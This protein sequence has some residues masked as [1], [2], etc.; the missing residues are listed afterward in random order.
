LRYAAEGKASDVH[1]EPMAD[2]IRVRFRVDGTLNTSLVLP[3]EVHQAV[4]ARIKILSN[5]RLD[6][7]RKPQDGR[8]SAKIEGRKIDFVFLNFSNLLW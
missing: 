1:I 8:F 7:K 5:M 6:E 4:V 2:K 3:I